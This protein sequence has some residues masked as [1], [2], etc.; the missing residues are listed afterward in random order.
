MLVTI[1]HLPRE[2]YRD[3]RGIY[4]EDER[5]VF[6]K[7]QLTHNNYVRVAEFEVG[8]DIDNKLSLAYELT[9]SIQNAWYENPNINVS[10]EAKD[11]CRSTSIGDLIQIDGR[12]YMV[13]GC[14]FTEIT[15]G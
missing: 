14:G 2:A 10:E 8:K 1:R 13:A 4:D 6:A 15:K 12:S 7:D 11:G 3:M 9:N 5:L